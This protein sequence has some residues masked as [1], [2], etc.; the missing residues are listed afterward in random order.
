MWEAIFYVMQMFDNNNCYF[1]CLIGNKI[2]I[3]KHLYLHKNK[4]PFAKTIKSFI[5][6]RR[7][8]DGY[9]SIPI[10]LKWT[11]LSIIFFSKCKI[12][13]T[14]SFRKCNQ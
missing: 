4:L 1:Y 7:Y 13:H 12:D 2:S 9:H 8:I 14:K 10:N 6:L 3:S 11:T 5:V